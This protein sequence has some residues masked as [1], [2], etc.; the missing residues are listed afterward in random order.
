M[1][2]DAPTEAKV[3]AAEY[4]IDDPA[5]LQNMRLSENIDDPESDSILIIKYTPITEKLIEKLKVFKVDKGFAEPVV[6]ESISASIEHVE[7]TFTVIEGILVEDHS[8]VEDVAVAL[9]NRKQMRNLENLILDNLDEIDSLFSANATEKLVALTQHHNGTARH[10]LIAAFQL[11][12]IGRE[13][14]WSDSKIVKAAMALINHD[15]GKAKVNLKTLDCP[16]KLNN[17]QWKEIQFHPLFGCRMLYQPDREPDL[18]MLSALLHH[19]WYASVEGKGYGGLTLYGDFVKRAMKFD[20]TQLVAE[21]D[22]DSR[23]IVQITSLADMISA[24]EESRAY[25]RGLDSFKVLIIMNSDAK[26]GHFHPDHYRAWHKI[27]CI[28]HPNMLPMGRRMALPR[29]KENRIFT[30]LPPQKIPPTALLTHYEMDKLGILP[31][32]RNVGM[33]IGRN[34]SILTST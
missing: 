6:E 32:L 30:G 12:A 33:D 21:M 26:L 28:Q 19:E 4:Q 11:M 5:L 10:S 16:G 20:V 24:L 31:L 17:K 18:I 22:E 3:E 13:L 27:Y 14:G 23:D 25:K 8:N 7:K 34:S 2:S 29:E 9:N 1:S 15:I